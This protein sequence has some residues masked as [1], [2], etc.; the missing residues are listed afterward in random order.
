MSF[1]LNNA[2]LN[3]SR[4]NCTAARDREHVFDRH[5]E[6]LIDF[7]CWSWDLFIDRFHQ[8]FNLADVVWIA[9][10]SFQSRTAD[11]RNVFVAF[12]FQ[13]FGQ[14]HFDE[15]DQLFVAFADHV[16][17]VEENDDCRNAD[18]TGEQNVLFRLRHRTI[19]RSDDENRAVHLSRTGDHVLDIVGVAGAVDVSIVAIRCF[20][21]NV[22][23]VD[24]NPARFFFW[25]VVDRSIVAI[26]RCSLISQYF[27]DRCCQRRFTMVNVAN[28]SDVDVGFFR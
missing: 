19:C 2:A 18:L 25:R 12:R 23:R 13:K 4:H 9:F 24:G 7:A 22:S 8:F 3:A 27:R 1:T 10:E 6:W 20:I 17:L 28:R 26:F 21:F 14:F 11:D 5:Q 15:L 16:H